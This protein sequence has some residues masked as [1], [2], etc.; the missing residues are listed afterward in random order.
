M[1]LELL[2]TLPNPLWKPANCPLCA[3][4]IL[5]DDGSP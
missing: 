4:G 3:Q 2:A 1:T 5:L